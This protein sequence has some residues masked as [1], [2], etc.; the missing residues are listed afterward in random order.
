MN[1]AVTNAVPIFELVA[2]CKRYGDTVALNPTHL[3]ISPGKTSVLIGPSGSGKSTLIR[4]MAG[5]IAPDQGTVRFVG[6]PI[7]RR[8]IN[9]VRQKRGF[10]VQEGGGAVSTHERRSQCDAHGTSAWLG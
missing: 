3:T 1:K 8:N 5:L 6:K 2:V 4:I 9:R 10:V 7:N